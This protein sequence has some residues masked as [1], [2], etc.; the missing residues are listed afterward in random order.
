MMSKPALTLVIVLIPAP[1]SIEARLAEKLSPAKPDAGKRSKYGEKRLIK[2]TEEY[3]RRRQELDEE[4]DEYMRQTIK[5]Q[6]PDY[7]D[8]RLL[9]FV[10]SLKADN[11]ALRERISSMEKDK[12][13]QASNTMAAK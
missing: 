10:E 13:L 2:G 8:E 7:L 5:Q 1:K 4:L 12:E 6:T 9:E 3:E 11:A